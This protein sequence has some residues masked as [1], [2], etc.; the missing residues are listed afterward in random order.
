MAGDTTVVLRKD[1]DV[2]APQPGSH[3]AELRR[4]LLC[5]TIRAARE[6]AEERSVLGILGRL[7]QCEGTAIAELARQALFYPATSAE[8]AGKAA[9][10]SSNT[11]AAWMV[12]DLF[13][14]L[15]R[16]DRDLPRQ[17]VIVEIMRAW[18][19][20]ERDARQQ[21][22]GNDFLR[23]VYSKKNK[24]LV[25]ADQQV[26]LPAKQGAFDALSAGDYSIP[27]FLDWMCAQPQ[28]EL[29]PIMEMLRERVRR[30]GYGWELARTLL[31]HLEP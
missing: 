12:S 17:R 15:L 31:G 1:K 30:R 28:D 25:L 19:A 11:A 20:Q 7:A 22:V 9:A 27:S 6:Y 3:E 4:L 18:A 10:M 14:D 21:F 5:G 16:D 8:F 24:G 2:P 26:R 13:N 23:L 29:E